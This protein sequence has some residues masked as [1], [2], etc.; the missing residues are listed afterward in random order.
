MKVFWGVLIIFL[1]FNGCGT[2]VGNPIKEATV[3]GSGEVQ[4][5]LTLTSSAL[6]GKV[7]DKLV[8]C[9]PSQFNADNCANIIN[10]VD[11]FDDAFNLNNSS[12]NDYE[13]IEEAEKN[14]LI[15][16]SSTEGTQ[17]QDDIEALSCTD[18]E[19]INA[20]D[21]SNSSDY[22]QLYNIIPIGS[23]SCQ[24]TFTETE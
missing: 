10:N 3:P 13:D 2:E 12:Y 11:G 7:C 24:D 14:E 4:D 15:E 6:R 23:G 19:V 8:E 16:V 21:E 22:T 5:P 9:F 20:Y 1:L 17:C 18:S